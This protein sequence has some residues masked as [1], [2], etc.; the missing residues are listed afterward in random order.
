MSGLALATGGASKLASAITIRRA[1]FLRSM[2][3]GLYD[4]A[5]FIARNYP[6]AAVK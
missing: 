4:D 2:Q 3:K 6:W 1:F 5:R